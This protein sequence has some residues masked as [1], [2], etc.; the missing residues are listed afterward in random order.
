M[1]TPRQLKEFVNK[2]GRNQTSEFKT[3]PAVFNAKQFVCDSDINSIMR[4]MDKDGD[5]LLSFTDFFATMLPYFIYYDPYEAQAKKDQKLYE[6][7]QQSKILLS[8]NK[9]IKHTNTAAMARAMS[10]GTMRKKQ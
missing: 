6:E 3:T 8:N 2:H 4:K 1:L 10:A 5:G 9:E 7:Y